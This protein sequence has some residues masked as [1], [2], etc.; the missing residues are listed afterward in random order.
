MKYSLKKLKRETKEHGKSNH[1]D[2]IGK[3]KTMGNSIWQTHYKKKRREE[4]EG[5]T[6]C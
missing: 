5:E 6:I 1:T 3:I 2:A 4:R